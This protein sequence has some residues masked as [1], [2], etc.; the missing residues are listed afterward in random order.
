MQD[1]C[2]LCRA[3]RPDVFWRGRRFYAID[4]GGEDFPAFVR[5]VAVGHVPEMTALDPDARAE[6]RRLLDAAE[7]AMIDGLCPDKM[8]WAQFGNMVPHLHWHLI[9]RWR[10]DGFYPECPWGPRRRPTDAA[11]SA[12]RRARFVKLLPEIAARL[13]AAEAAQ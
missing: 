11:K 8:N 5:I 4:A 10:D 3:D 6:L 1:N 2:E 13:S 12:E 9:A 7:A